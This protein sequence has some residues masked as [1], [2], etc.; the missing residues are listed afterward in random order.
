MVLRIAH[1][2]PA[3]EPI[4]FSA[5]SGGNINGGKGHAKLNSP[6]DLQNVRFAAGASPG[7]YV[8]EVKHGKESHT[9]E[10]WVGPVPPI[11]QSGP[12]RKFTGN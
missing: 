5:P 4:T 3:D 10:F 12:D 11:G 7:L 1:A 9:I 8:L 6:A 2:L